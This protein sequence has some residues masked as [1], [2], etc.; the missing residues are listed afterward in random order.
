M[1][2]FTRPIKLAYTSPGNAARQDARVWNK[3]SLLRYATSMLHS[4]HT[5]L[6]RHY[7]SCTVR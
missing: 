2:V 3:Q 4:N 5:L 6:Q 1:S 7:E